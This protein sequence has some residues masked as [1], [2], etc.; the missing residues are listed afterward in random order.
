MSDTSTLSS[1]HIELADAG[2]VQEYFHSR[3]WTD[4]LPI[5]PPTPDAVRACLDW[6]LLAPD[7]LVGIEPVRERAITAEKVAVNAVMAGCAARHLPLVL[8][9][10]QAIAS[11]EFNL[12]GVQTTDENVAPLLLFSGPDPAA[13]DLNSGLGALGPGWQGNASVGR[14]LWYRSSP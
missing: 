9:A 13:Y 4:G 11:P 10:V 3:G 5:V 6:A 14:A 1:R 8:A 7:H 2:D 12:R